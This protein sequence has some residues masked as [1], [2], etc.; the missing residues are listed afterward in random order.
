MWYR[1]AAR[2]CEVLRVCLFSSSS[3]S[4][5]VCGTL[6]C[7][8][9]A[10]SDATC[11][12]VGH[13]AYIRVYVS[14][15]PRVYA[16]LCAYLPAICPHVCNH[17]LNSVATDM[18]TKS[19]SQSEPLTGVAHSAACSQS[20]QH[21]GLQATRRPAFVF[22]LL[23]VLWFSLVSS[24]HARPTDEAVGRSDRSGSKR[25]LIHERRIGRIWEQAA[26]LSHGRPEGNCD[27][28]VRISNVLAETPS[29]RRPN[30]EV[31]K[32]P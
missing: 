10:E 19:A 23:G 16:A 29:Q 7:V 17:L 2:I 18:L 26:V 13:P 32:V 30:I 24:L 1:A 11:L 9:F 25:G 8:H 20:Q 22:D 15:Y 14:A 12:V 6:R 27:K 31:R 4:S 28:S 21:R 3:S 5:C